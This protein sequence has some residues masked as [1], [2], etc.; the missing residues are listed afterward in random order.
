M[1]STIQTF[2]SGKLCF[3]CIIW[4][5]SHF[6]HLESLLGIRSSVHRALNNTETVSFGVCFDFPMCIHAEVEYC[7]TYT[8]G[9]TTVLEPQK[10]TFWTWSWK[11]LY[12]N[13]AWCFLQ[14]CAETQ[15]TG[16][17][18]FSEC[19]FAFVLY[20][21]KPEECN[22]T[23]P[24]AHEANR[25]TFWRSCTGVS[26][27]RPFFF[28]MRCFGYRGHTDIQILVGH[29]EF[30]L[31][32]L[33]GIYGEQKATLLCRRNRSA[34]FSWTLLYT[35]LSFAHS[36]QVKLFFSTKLCFLCIMHEFGH[37]SIS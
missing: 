22:M 16:K 1:F 33:L 15:I 2:V 11:L 13:N 6:D 37:S 10:C 20:G 34:Y 5:C 3:L 24:I 14:F 25:S 28:I 31:F 21:H 4:I 35:R 12:V 7:M 18:W 17:P 9:N 23:W 36:L 8:K 30:L 27:K 26:W 29:D 19:F 32:F